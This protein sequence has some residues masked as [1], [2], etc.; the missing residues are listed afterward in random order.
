MRNDLTKLETANDLTILLTKLGK[1]TLRGQRNG[2]RVDLIEP[3]KGDRAYY[4][5]ENGKILGSG[6]IKT[7]HSYLYLD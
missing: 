6:P 1:R 7:L 5:Y 3:R 2:L 4:V